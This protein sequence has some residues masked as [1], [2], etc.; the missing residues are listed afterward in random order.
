MNTI[1]N[2]SSDASQVTHITLDDGSTVDM[3]LTYLPT[4]Q[5]W[6]FSISHPLLT[7]KGRL[8]RNS[9]NIL[10]A[11]KNII[12]FGI[13]C[14]VSDDTEPFLQDDFV[15]GRVTLVLLNTADVLTMEQ[16]IAAL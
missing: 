12:P 11:F 5:S 10:R 15:N 7:T 8:L 9:P 3:T 1:D 4:I 2:L 13:S 16:G 6:Q 14:I